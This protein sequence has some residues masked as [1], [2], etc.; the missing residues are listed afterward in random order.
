MSVSAAAPS[1][2]SASSSSSST[3]IRSSSVGILAGDGRSSFF[4]L[5]PEVAIGLALL[6]VFAGPVH[7]AMDV[8]TILS[9]LGLIASFTLDWHHLWAAALSRQKASVV[10]FLMC[11]GS[12]DFIIFS[13]SSTLVRQSGIRLVAVF[14]LPIHSR[15]AEPSLNTRVL[16]PVDVT[17]RMLSS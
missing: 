13:V 5:F 14:Q 7:D 16:M 12:T 1:G 3:G 17:S 11:S 9:L 15:S 8:R 6:A 10:A 4:V 2:G